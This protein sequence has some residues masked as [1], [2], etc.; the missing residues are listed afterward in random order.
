[1]LDAWKEGGLILDD[2]ISKHIN[3]RNPSKLHKG[4]L[5]EYAYPYL[6][7]Q[8]LEPSTGVCI[9]YNGESKLEPRNNRIRPLGTKVPHHLGPFC[10]NHFQTVYISISVPTI[11]VFVHVVSI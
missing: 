1:M 2:K 10:Y 6:C 8:C 7:Q 4:L 11:R 9:S 5:L 3:D